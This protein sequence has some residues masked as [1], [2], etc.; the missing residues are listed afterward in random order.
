MVEVWG[1]YHGWHLPVGAL[2]T[3]SSGQVTAQPWGRGSCGP[4]PRANP[5]VLGS[6]SLPCLAQ[7]GLDLGRHPLEPGLVEEAMGHCQKV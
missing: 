3:Q 1:R 2:G 4:D 6:S 7:A 5:R